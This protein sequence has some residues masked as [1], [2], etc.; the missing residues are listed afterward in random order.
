MLGLFYCAV[1]WVFGMLVM[2]FHRSGLQVLG[3]VIASIGI[4]TL[5]FNSHILL[6]LCLLLFG[7][8]VHS[9]GRLLMH[10][11]RRG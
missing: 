6:A 7:F 3:A 2:I 5:I 8:L 11:K 10:L 4:I 1:L 9:C